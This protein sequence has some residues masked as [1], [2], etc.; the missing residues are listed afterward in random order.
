M[1]V[2]KSALAKRADGKVSVPSDGARCKA[3]GAKEIPSPNYKSRGTDSP[4]K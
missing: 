2:N 3:T 4:V 1:A